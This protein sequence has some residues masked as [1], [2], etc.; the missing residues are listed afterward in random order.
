MKEVTLG[1]LS[2]DDLYPV[3]AG[4]KEGDQVVTRGAFLVDSEDRL[5]PAVTPAN[6]GKP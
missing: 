6:G 5:N 1:A 3:L 2:A 4:L